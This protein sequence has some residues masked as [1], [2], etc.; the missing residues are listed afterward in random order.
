LLLAEI[1]DFRGI[2][3]VLMSEVLHW[4]VN[5]NEEHILLCSY[6]RP[7]LVQT[8][9]DYFTDIRQLEQSVGHLLSSQQ[10][11]LTPDIVAHSAS[12]YSFPS[13]QNLSLQIFPLLPKWITYSPAKTKNE[14]SS[15]LDQPIELSKTDF[16]LSHNEFYF[17]WDPD[18][19]MEHFLL[20]SSFL[21]LLP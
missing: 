11:L 3:I 10:A 18:M 19:L 5:M 14:V 4:S 8:H 2:Y 13:Y 1:F 17:F 7:R 20:I 15:L 6:D 12:T 16:D 21:D 9:I